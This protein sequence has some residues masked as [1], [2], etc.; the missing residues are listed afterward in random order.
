MTHNS[1]KIAALSPEKR[2]LLSLMMQKRQQQRPSAALIQPRED[3]S[4][5]P[6]SFSQK[7]L[8]F[9]QQ[10]NPDDISYNVPAA[11]HL[12]GRL[13]VTALERAFGEIV[14][15]HEALRTIISDTDEVPRQVIQ[16]AV[17]L[18]LTRSSVRA[19]PA[20]ERMAAA[21]QLAEE[22]ARAP[23]D[24]GRGPLL[25][26]LLIE[27]DGEEH[28]L[29]LTMHHIVFDGW[30]TGILIR[31]LV[32]LYNALAAGQQPDLPELPIQYA[33]F[34][35]WQNRHLEGETFSRLLSFWREK[36]A[37]S[38]P[39]IVLPPAGGRA[40]HAKHNGGRHIELLPPGLAAR[41]QALSQQAG[42]TPFMIYLAVFYALLHRYSGQHDL[43][44][45]TPV[46]NRNHRELEGLIGFFV[47]TLVMRLD[48]SGDPTFH[49]LLQRV[50][51]TALD[52]LDHQEMPIEKLVEELNPERSGRQNPLFNV[53]FD[54][55]AAPLKALQLAGLETR[56]IELA[57]GVA[58]FDLNLTVSPDLEEP[59]LAIEYRRDLYSQ[60]MIGRFARHYVNLLTIMT[61]APGE[62]LSA[63]DFLTSVEHRELLHDWNNTPNPASIEAT[64]HALFEAQAER[65]PAA[66]AVT[67]DDETISYAELNSRANQLAALLRRAGVKPETLVGLCVE[68][69]VAMLVG[70]LAIFKA[71]G[72]YVPLD[73]DY[74]PE[75]LG[76]IIEASG[77]NYLVT[78]SHLPHRLTAS[79]S[80]NVLLDLQAAEI[81]AESEAN[82]PATT[83]PGNLAYVLF[84]SGSTGKP[85]G[86]MI[87]HRSAVNLWH[88][89]VEH[90]YRPYAGQSLS[91][92]LNAPLLFDA[93]VQQLLVL[94][95]G[96][97]LVILPAEIRADA[98]ALFDFIER[99][100]L[101][102]FD[103]VPSQLKVLVNS[104]RWS[105][106]RHLPRLVLVGGEALDAETWEKLQR[107][108]GTEYYNVY[109]PTECTVDTAIY[110]LSQGSPEPT[111]G[112][113]MLATQLYI[114]DRH[115]QLVPAGVA[116]QLYIGGEQ[117]ARGYYNRPDLTA[118]RFIPNPF[119]ETPG[120]RLY[121]SG[122]LA[123]YREDG[124]IEYIGRMDNQVKIRGFRI[125]LEEIE[126]ALM[127]HPDV[128]EAAVIV[129]ENPGAPE[130]RRLVAYCALPGHEAA[131]ASRA[132][133]DH[134]KASL[135]YYMIPAAV[136]VLPQLPKTPNGK[137]DR[138][139]LPRPDEATLRHL[140]DY[141]PPTRPVE[142]IIAS[143]WGKLL[144][145]SRIGLH[146]N[147]FALGGHSLLATQ[148][149]ARLRQVFSIEL[150]LSA[151]FEEPTLA[152][153][154]ETVE[155]ARQQQKQAPR[156]IE[157]APEADNYPLAFAQQRMWFLNQMEP[158]SPFYNI[159]GA[160]RI[161]G[162]LQI[163]T[164]EEAI[165]RIIAR[166]QSLHTTF[167]LL[168]DGPVQKVAPPFRIALPVIDLGEATEA[169]R[170]DEEMRLLKEESSQGFD[171]ARGPLIRFRLI[172]TAAEH[173]LL[174]VNMH[175]I[176]ADGWSMAIFIRELQ[177]F[178]QAIHQGLQPALPE[179]TVQYRDYACW[180]R[181]W[182]EDE[183]LQLQLAYWR[184][185]LRGSTALLEIPADRPRP[186]VQSYR[187]ATHAFQIPAPVA[188]SLRELSRQEEVTLFMTLLAAFQVQLQRYTG[189][190]DL[191]I[192][193]PIANRTQLET[194]QLI[195]FFV[196]TL[197][198]RTD[199]SGSPTF[200]ELLQ[201]VR[202]VALEAYA[203]QDIPFE[204]VVDELRP[205]RDLSYSPLF[206]V[207]FALQ[208]MPEEKLEMSG[209]Q[210]GMIEIDNGTSQFDLSLIIDEVGEELRCKFE[211]S[212]DL[213]DRATIERMTGHLL[214]LLA[215]LCHEPDLPVARA[216]MLPDFEARQILRVWNDTARE[217]PSG[218]PLHRLI[219]EQ[220]ERHPEATALIAGERRLSYGELN[221]RANQLA[222][223][224]IRQ[225]VGPG[226]IVGI[227]LEQSPE[228]I[229]SLLA[230]L[231]S[232]A[233]Y[234]PLDPAYP[235]ER[236]EHMIQDAGIAALV[237]TTKL[238]AMLPAGSVP[239]AALDADE[240][241][242]LALSTEN[243]RVAV[244]GG[245]WAY[246]IYTSGTTGQPKGVLISH[247]AVVNHNTYIVNHFN[248]GPQD[249]VLQFFSISFDAA[250]EEIFPA[251]LSGACLVLR[252]EAT[253]LAIPQLMELVERAKITVLDL[254]T[255]YWHEW[256]LE[257]PMLQKPIPPSLRL[258]IVGGEQ[259][260]LDRLREWQQRAN[261]AIRWSNTYGPTEGTIIASLFEPDY[262][263]AAGAA[264][265]VLP[266]GRPIDNVRIF[267]LDP[268]RQQVPIGLAGELCI[269][270]VGVAEGYLGKADLT[271]EKFIPDPY[272][273][274]AGARMYRTGDLARFLADGN[275]EYLGRIDNQ[276][277]IRGF[278]IELGE[279]EQ[280]LRLHPAVREAVVVSHEEEGSARRLVAYL[281]PRPGAP[282]PVSEIRDLIKNTLPNYMMPS[283]F[284]FLESLPLTPAGKIDRKTLAALPVAMAEGGDEYTAPQT[285]AEIGLA[286]IWQ[287]VLR[288]NQIGLDD[289]FFELGGDS[290]QTIQVIAQA[291]EE[292]MHLSPKQLFQNPTIRELAVVAD[293]SRASLRG[294]EDLTGEFPLT[295]IMRWFV[296][297]DFPDP[298]HWNQSVALDVAQKMAYGPLRSAL[299]K[300][301][302][303]HDA[304]RLRLSGRDGDW[305]LSY[306]RETGEPPLIFVD[307]SQLTAAQQEATMAY[308][309][310]AA[311]R[312][313][314]LVQGPIVRVL[315]F[316]LG[317]EKNDR[318]F[319]AIHHLSSDGYSWR[320]LFGD[321]LLAY[322]QAARGET[323]VLPAKS[324]SV[325]LWAQQLAIYAQSDAFTRVELDYWQRLA[326]HGM[327]PLP[328]D[329]YGENSEASTETV[330]L[331]LDAEETRQLL[332]EAPAAYNTQINDLLLTAL[333]RTLARW[334]GHK[335][336]WVE[337]ESHG[338]EDL[339]DDID[340]SRT[341]GWFTAAYPVLLDLRTAASAADEI[342]AI[343]EQ[344]RRIPRN[345]IGFG[346][347]RYLSADAAIRE[348]LAR[349]AQPQVS[350]NYL[351]QFDNL[352]AASR[353]AFA[354]VQSSAER[355]PGA[356]RAHA[357]DISGKIANDRLE[358]EFAY[359]RHLHRRET[360]VE[361][362][363]RYMAD[364]RDLIAH[365][366]ASDGG[367]YTPSD[368]QDAGL[369]QEEIDALVNELYEEN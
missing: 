350:F 135:P 41:V 310:D 271:A 327:V 322:E 52:A 261:S 203:N 216:V 321:I 170:E 316:D 367:V 116:G 314:D 241:A 362:S 111:I 102:S 323:P 24:L 293:L 133:T 189:Q 210:L 275:V 175:H 160:V 5:T 159:T 353:F 147:F 228:M 153:L 336:V 328:A 221:R 177:L 230:I 108:Q 174:T 59:R 178:Y 207:M 114:L 331:V 57:T 250:I 15:R 204:M 150:P 38:T 87:Q 39:G 332:R 46:A 1:D 209:L 343:K 283:V 73:P 266:I 240:P 10:L 60:G 90:I 152:A 95:A 107:H 188:A 249:H 358:M 320:L 142:V 51:Q 346:I 89:L 113:P 340:L 92:S 81:A 125:E 313:L 318:L 17:P 222:H 37:G 85:K 272:S 364:L 303:H 122:D 182:L 187:G 312:S 54:L 366:L 195:G 349:I 13:D 247:R 34:S 44:I 19:L 105:T 238:A 146:D 335:E 192:G 110:P 282:A 252:Q 68:R 149:A 284:V 162:P 356:E 172:R 132:V 352:L 91:C 270:G 215:S 78:F 262:G 276:V 184:E 225:G 82:L 300:I 339:S 148:L 14:R 140:D 119:G 186:A 237:T 369:T 83:A 120:S 167:D 295:P 325:K 245:N 341:I 11:L 264:L 18:T 99:H 253:V 235:R 55:E 354:A 185:K 334:T 179:L 231:K 306:G 292:G 26:T 206:Q 256:V 62:H 258:V 103:C 337:M 171:L 101:D 287:N 351:G 315:Y 338:R 359:S 112:G 196:N 199:L 342:I 49:E 211:Y 42:V 97:R 156:P 219:E 35:W 84:T 23:F 190:S 130:S 74:P 280:V 319:M 8:W 118:E 326:G 291:N 263:S 279:I 50:R 243:P 273:G 2:A 145:T 69:S 124:C 198:L 139:A 163:A 297:R 236:L 360:I 66:P 248:L 307:L 301:I 181:Q 330:T 143:I 269:A 20:G 169:E 158:D 48:L 53:M 218:T 348:S 308:E 88:G 202:G 317:A 58:K 274:V 136:I 281:L 36:L 208:N 141:L 128:K 361:L 329:F 357:I 191:N 77:L 31:E 201:R 121:L 234:L 176:I 71:G 259:A 21:L 129:Q 98:D 4:A 76:Y 33:D 75:R 79:G 183:T 106:A 285:L 123:R 86:V 217:Y 288:L 224:L 309:M 302:S 138:R 304:L 43:A 80:V 365:C 265:Q 368:F 197:V 7:R 27:L 3:R 257:L 16:T 115:M 233:A 164:L 65:T 229:C 22:Q 25:R 127:R 180:Q 311:Q 67:F 289:N 205:E 29:C 298:G 45:G 131:A 40:D 61:G 173:Y 347:L 93:S 166:H 104:E 157:P 109:G 137:I 251:L 96:H 333:A 267:I 296:E 165:T 28:L 134:L 227:S 363:R 94:T 244:D 30:S 56:L 255:A 6:L 9:L 355:S 242:I 344:L 193:T 214:H 70:L 226:D 100:R 220:V 12:K 324:S 290:I 305:S 278:R 63:C 72:A 32:V 117:L 155:R 161:E 294:S 212:T 239:I 246:V 213:F 144:G 345:G 260:S 254:P 194:E 277:K 223:Y 151:I 47:N 168:P 268:Q 200:R 154:V 126:A 232:G 286:K 299:Q 64:F